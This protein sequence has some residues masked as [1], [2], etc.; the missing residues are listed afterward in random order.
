MLLFTN[1]KYQLIKTSSYNSRK[2]YKIMRNITKREK[3]AYFKQ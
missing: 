1:K 3:F 2:I